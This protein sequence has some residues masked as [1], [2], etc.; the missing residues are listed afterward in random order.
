MSA[1]F[2]P[3]VAKPFAASSAHSSS[4]FIFSGFGPNTT[5]YLI[6][7]EVFASPVRGTLHGISAASGKMGAV[8]GVFVVAW[9]EESFGSSLVLVLLGSIA[10]AGAVVT[11]L[12]IPDSTAVSLDVE[13]KQFAEAA[14]AFARAQPALQQGI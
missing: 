2:F 1:S 13:E 12:C 10:F 7:S 5:T 6:P 9:L 14:A 3:S 8:V 11:R 4:T